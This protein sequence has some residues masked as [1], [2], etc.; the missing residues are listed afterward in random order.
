MKPELFRNQIDS[1]REAWGM[2]GLDII[3]TV[4]VCALENA[5]EI[6]EDEELM[7][8]A[9]LTGRDLCR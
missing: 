7:R 3:E 1:M 5:E 8:N 2:A 6:M 4:Q 9:F